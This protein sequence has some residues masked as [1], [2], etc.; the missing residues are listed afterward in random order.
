VRPLPFRRGKDAIPGVLGLYFTSGERRREIAMKKTLDVYK[1]DA[2][3]HAAKKRII[4][5]N[6]ETTE[7]KV[8][9][10]SFQMLK[11]RLD[12]DMGDS[13]AAME[14]F[15]KAFEKGLYPPDWTLEWIAQGFINFRNYYYHRIS[16]TDPKSKRKLLDD[17]LGLSSKKRLTQ[18]EKDLTHD[19]N[20][21]LFM[22]VSSLVALDIPPK[23]AFLRVSETMKEQGLSHTS[24]YIRKQYFHY[25]RI[26]PDC[27]KNFKK[28]IS[29]WTEADK[30]EFLSHYD[31][32]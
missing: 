31:P 29:T 16:Q 13:F 12:F 1:P 23:K 32:S 27:I 14:A 28:R 17:F 6:G 3:N 30:K 18:T 7:I 20:F 24:A 4:L 9:E 8:D 10:I 11:H 25:K 19:K 21:H 2:F 22:A 5:P 26:Y 15:I